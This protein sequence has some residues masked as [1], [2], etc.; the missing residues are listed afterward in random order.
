MTSPHTL[1]LGAV[2][3]DPK[4]VT[5]WRGFRDYFLHNG[6][7]FDFV[8]FSNYE[9]Q[10]LAHFDGTIHLAWN[11]PLAWLQSEQIAKAVGRHAVAVMM[12]DTDWD[13]ASVIVVKTDSG[14]QSLS[15]LRDKRVAVG[16][17]D[18]PQ[19]TL[20]PLYELASAGLE[21]DADFEI[22]EFDTAL[23]LHG[24]HNGGERE[25]VLALVNGEV[26]AACLLEANYQLFEQEG[27]LNADSTKALAHTPLFDRRN[28]TVMDG[29]PTKEIAKFC[30][31]L[32][33][34]S[35]NDPVLRPLLE[36]EGL[37]RW[38]VGRVRGYTALENAIDRF[39][40]IEEFVDSAKEKYR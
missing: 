20:I 16:A 12:R 11:S 18:S 19:A 9:Q 33:D 25:A 39:G 35:H 6:L 14:F 3:Y 32:Q 30:E 34:M 38:K 26:D 2:A 31:L 8:L 4:V 27:V 21:P 29:A 13:L 24:E 7:N 17:K 10:V 40:T 23:G 36:M 37:N 22:V 1:L 28:F 15:D 5:I